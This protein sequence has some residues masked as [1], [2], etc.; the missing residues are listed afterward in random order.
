MY[1]IVEDFNPNQVAAAFIDL[2]KDSTTAKDDNGQFYEFI[3]ENVVLFP[4]LDTAS[5]DAI[6]HANS[7]CKEVFR[8]NE[9]E[10]LE[11]YK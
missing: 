9:H 6:E 1:T 7:L 2:A 11:N 10:I 8:L 4:G 5:Q 3:R